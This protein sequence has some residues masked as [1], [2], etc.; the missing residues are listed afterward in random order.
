MAIASSS[1]IV[2]LF[3]PPYKASSTIKTKQN[4]TIFPTLDHTRSFPHFKLSN[5]QWTYNRQLH[6]IWLLSVSLNS[7]PSTFPLLCSNQVS[8]EL[9][10][11]EERHCWCLALS[12]L[13]LKSFQHSHSFLS[14]V[15]MSFL[16][17]WRLSLVQE[18]AWPPEVQP[19]TA[20]EL[21]PQ[22]QYSDRREGR[23]IAQLPSPPVGRFWGEL[24]MRAPW[25][26]NKSPVSIT[27]THLYHTLSLSTFFVSSVMLHGVTPPNKLSVPG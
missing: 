10:S 19:K 14:L 9:C 22:Q 1:I 21:T 16:S 6:F 15:P 11:V 27:V 4:K 3:L 7:S 8:F 20:G 5:G 17:V 25:K 23:Y 2:P 26:E 18:C 13:Q 24:Q 12:S